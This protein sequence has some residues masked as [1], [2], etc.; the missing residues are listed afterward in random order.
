ME[1]FCILSAAM[2]WYHTTVSLDITVSLGESNA[3]GTGDFPIQLHTNL[4]YCQNKSSIKIANLNIL[5]GA[6]D[7]Y[8]VMISI[9][10]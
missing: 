1:M 10:S 7:H 8:F 2:L 9:G 3:E 5:G 6:K 4:Q